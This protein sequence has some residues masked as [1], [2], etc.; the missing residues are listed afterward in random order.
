MKEDE[1]VSDERWGK[2]FLTAE[3]EGRRQEE[4]HGE[5]SCRAGASKAS[6]GGREA[7]EDP[8]PGG[9]AE[10]ETE[11]HLRW[12]ASSLAASGVTAQR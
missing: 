4:T 2:F 1:N 12:T 8:E 7:G 3:Q 10:T 6:I 11:Q 9:G 5:G